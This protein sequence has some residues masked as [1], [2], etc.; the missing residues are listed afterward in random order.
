LELLGCIAPVTKHT[1]IG[2]GSASKKALVKLKALTKV[3][4][5]QNEKVI[6][7]IQFKKETL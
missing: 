3:A 6:L 5:K 2:K 4:F 1:G 7:K